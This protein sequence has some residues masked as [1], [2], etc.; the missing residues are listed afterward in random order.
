M[1]IFVDKREET[2]FFQKR[3]LSELYV[4]VFKAETCSYSLSCFSLAVVV[5]NGGV[6]LLFI[7]KNYLRVPI[8]PFL[9]L[10]N[11]SYKNSKALH[12]KS[13]NISLNWIDFHQNQL[14]YFIIVYIIFM[15]QQ[16]SP[17]VLKNR[18]FINLDFKTQSVS[19]FI[20]F[21][22]FFVIIFCDYRCDF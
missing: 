17:L 13:K 7:E 18:Y 12:S 4:Y 6:S 22:Q 19:Y 9:D 20:I 16:L 10:Y 1:I 8:L 2:D 5:A 21:R 11:Y 15:Y 3:V 14:I